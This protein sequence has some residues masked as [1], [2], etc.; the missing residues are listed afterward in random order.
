MPVLEEET[1]AKLYMTSKF[2]SQDSNLG[3]LAPK[4]V[5]SIVSK[6]FPKRRCTH[7]HSSLPP[8][9]LTGHLLEA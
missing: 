6:F 9:K 2:Q 5:L 4:S 7:T 1:K 3:R 8:K